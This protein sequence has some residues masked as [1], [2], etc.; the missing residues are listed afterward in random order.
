MGLLADHSVAQTLQASLEGLSTRASCAQPPLQDM[1][2]LFLH[3][4]ALVWARIPRLWDGVASYFRTE[5]CTV[6]SP[7]L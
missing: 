5:R 1:L 4:G 7:V 3:L 6:H 2:Y